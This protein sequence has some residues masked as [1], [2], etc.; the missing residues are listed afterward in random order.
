MERRLQLLLDQERF[1]V[2]AA[3]A[4]RSGRSVA[5]VIREAIDVRFAGDARV[6]AQAAA[7]FLACRDTREGREPDWPDIKAAMEA[8]LLGQADAR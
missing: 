3:E 8:E 1:D 4:R 6:R 2:V 5:A 7:D